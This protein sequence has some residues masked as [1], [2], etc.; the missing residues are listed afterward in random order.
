M[1]EN[2]TSKPQDKNDIP[3]NKLHNHLINLHSAPASQNL[4]PTHINTIEKK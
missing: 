3:I 2:K 4:S 1:N